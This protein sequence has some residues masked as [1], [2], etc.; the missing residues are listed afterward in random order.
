MRNRAKHPE[1]A[2]N[3]AEKSPTAEL[4]PLIKN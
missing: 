3:H 2:A 4:K 1:K